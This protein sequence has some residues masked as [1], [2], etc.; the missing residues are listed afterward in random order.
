MS[1]IRHKNFI[2]ANLLFLLLM[3]SVL[4]PGKVETQPSWALLAVLIGMEA[5]CIGMYVV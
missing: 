4:L 5:V 2:L 3:V 1:K